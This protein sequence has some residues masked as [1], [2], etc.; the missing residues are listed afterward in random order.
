[1]CLCA[2][3]YMSECAH[4]HS[5]GRATALLT[6]P[7]VHF[8]PGAEQVRMCTLQMTRWMTR[9]GRELGCSAREYTLRSQLTHPPLPSLPSFIQGYLKSIVWRGKLKRE[10]FVIIAGAVS[11]S[12]NLA[13]IR[14]SQREAGWKRMVC[15]HGNHRQSC[16]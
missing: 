9:K 4:I 14:L 8:G 12:Q 7:A 2:C 15:F 16:S 1:M 13:F 6:S 3:V 5:S 10:S 11:K